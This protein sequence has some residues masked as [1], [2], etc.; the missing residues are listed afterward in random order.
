MRIGARIAGVNEERKPR[1]VVSLTP[2]VLAY[3]RPLEIARVPLLSFVKPL[4]LESAV[5]CPVERMPFSLLPEPDAA[6]DGRA[7]VWSEQ[8]A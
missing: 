6:F 1:T 7:A 4:V 5:R 3:N 8:C 2:A